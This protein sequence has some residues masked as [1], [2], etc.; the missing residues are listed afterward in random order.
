[1]ISPSSNPVITLYTSGLEGFDIIRIPDTGI[2]V[3]DV[4]KEIASLIESILGHVAA[5]R[6]GVGN[7]RIR[8]N[9]D[10]EKLLSYFDPLGANWSLR[11]LPV[12][13]GIRIHVSTLTGRR[14]SLT[15]GSNDTIEDIKRQ[16]DDIAEILSTMQRLIYAGE[17]LRDGLRL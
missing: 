9:A 4:Y 7:R 16:I 8:L 3:A 17:Q 13:K 10:A 1:M 6:I 2:T 15:V 11:V 5:F 14:L 12:K